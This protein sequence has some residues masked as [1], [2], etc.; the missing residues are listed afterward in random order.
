M[1]DAH[2]IAT[3]MISID[4]ADKRVAAERA[5]CAKIA[6][7]EEAHQRAIAERVA[8]TK[9]YQTHIDKAVTAERIARAIERGER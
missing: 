7:A 9:M 3:R 6:R 2:G 1:S 8:G 5:A 4:E